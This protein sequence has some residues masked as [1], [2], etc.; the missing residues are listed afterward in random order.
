ME[1]S[2]PTAT[3]WPNK[4]C[5]PP[6]LYM[7]IPP[8][9]GLWQG[10]NKTAITSRNQHIGILSYFKDQ[11]RLSIS[12]VTSTDVGMSTVLGTATSLVNATNYI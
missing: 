4:D 8:L 3:R 12:N 1:Q 6:S 9:A 11:S 10:D 7:R 5:K 2:M